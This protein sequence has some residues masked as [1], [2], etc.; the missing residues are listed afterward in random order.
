V[1]GRRTAAGIELAWVRRA[2][3]NVT[4]TATIPLDEP[5]EAYEVDILSGATVLRTL[6]VDA[7]HALYT[8]VAEAADFGGAPQSQLAVRVAQLSGTVGR[9]RANET[10]I[11]HLA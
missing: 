3:R 4:S 10:I 5:F 2:R 11:K 6:Q 8:T 7:P 9:G 1:R